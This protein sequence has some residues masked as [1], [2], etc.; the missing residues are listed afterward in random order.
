MGGWVLEE[1]LAP[2]EFREL[3]ATERDLPLISE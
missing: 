1:P 3:T 2:G